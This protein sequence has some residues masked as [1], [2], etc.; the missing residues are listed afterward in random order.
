[1]NQDTI[2]TLYKKFLLDE[3]LSV[4]EKRILI[5]LLTQSQ[6]KDLLPVAEVLNLKKEEISLSDAETDRILQAIIQPKKKI[7]LITIWQK[8]KWIAAAACLF[9][10]S[11]FSYYCFRATD[12]PQPEKQT[13]ASY[14]NPTKFLR[15]IKLQDGSQVTLREQSTLTIKS[16]F[17]SDS[18]REVSL[19]GQA[20]FEIAQHPTKPFIVRNSGNFDVRVLGTAFHMI[21]LPGH[22]TLSLNHG[23]VVVS[24][25]KLQQE[26]LPGEGVEYAADKNKFLVSTVDTLMAGLWKVDYITLENTA[27]TKIV[28]DLNLIHPS[29]KVILNKHYIHRQFSGALPINDLPKT[30]VILNNAF[31]KTIVTIKK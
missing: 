16:N 13:F 29:E 2:N 18:I 20:F 22:N 21:N 19:H 4:P 15:V 24:H 26:I 11:L 12:R 1:M 28:E 8:Y 14:A 31:N 9:L 23:K 6:A 25:K 17:T 3:S 10:A 30:L 7:F 5:A 27:L